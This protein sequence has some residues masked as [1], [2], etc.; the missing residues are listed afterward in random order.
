MRACRARRRS[1]CCRRR[2][3]SP[4]SPWTT[5]SSCARGRR[6]TSPCSTTTSPR[7]AGGRRSTRRRWSRRAMTALAFASGDL[8]RYLAPEEPGEY[9]IQYSVYTTG[10]PA[11][12]DTAD[13]RIQVLSDDANRAPLPETLEGRVLSGAVGAHR[14]RRVRHGP[15]RRRRDPRPDPDAARERR[16]DDLGRRRVDPLF[17]RRRVTVV[18][19]RSATA[20]WM[21]S[22]RRARG[23]SASESSTASPTR[24]PSPSPTTSRCRR[25]PTA[26]SA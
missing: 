7:P 26:R 4:R 2:P 1:T 20:S 23:P 16:G 6:S 25:A 22:A 11:L 10:S 24:V 19:C 12:A 5:P 14:V 8:L 9:G 17:E 15:R 21:R 3:N 18:R 13:V